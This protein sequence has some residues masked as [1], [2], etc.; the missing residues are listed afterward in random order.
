MVRFFGIASNGLAALALAAFLPASAAFAAD[1]VG[2]RFGVTSP[3][4]TRIVFDATE[5]PTYEL[6]AQS[7][8]AGQLDVSLTNLRR[9]GG[10]SASGKGAGH[11]AGYTV[12]SDGAGVTVSLN[13]KSP[14]KIKEIAI[15][16]PSSANPRFR[17]VI[18][19]VS[20][21]AGDLVA[22]L[23]A[24]KY[25]TLSQMIADVAPP[26]AA[27]PE[28]LPMTMATPAPP[29]LAAARPMP[30]IVIDAGHGGT[31]PG[32]S[33]PTGRQE[34]VATLSA[35]A[36]LAE[37]LRETGRYVVILTRSEDVRLAH[38]ERSRIARDAKADLFISLHADAHSDAKVRGGSVYTLSDEGTERS[39]REA[40]AKGNYHVFDLDIGEAKPEVGGILYDLAQRRTENESDRFAEMLIGKLAGVTPLL[41]NTHRRG[42]FKVLLAP[43]VPAVLLELA[44]ISNKH[45]EAN[46][47]SAAWRK[48]SMGAVAG[49][50]DTYFLQRAS[51]KHAS[52]ASPR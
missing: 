1:L 39:A 28:S 17:L 9:A 10:L 44:F 15:I 41:N 12:G 21:K 2:V 25:E 46:L 24:K 49:A 26:A 33:G 22:S 36:A 4:A 31:D 23:P 35:A 43:D 45:D 51:T 50:I 42:N 30:T 20:A 18:D 8:G 3:T 52:N 34:S 32:A 6:A 14:T 16:P 38:E 40:L 37:I 48:R 19:L 29:T 47:G 5:T 27:P 11:V 7:A 13:L